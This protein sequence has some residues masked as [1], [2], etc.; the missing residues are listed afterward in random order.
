MTVNECVR[1]YGDPD[2]FAEVEE[3]KILYEEVGPSSDEDALGAKY[4]KWQ[5]NLNGVQLHGISNPSGEVFRIRYL[6]DK[7]QSGWVESRKSL[8]RSYSGVWKRLEPSDAELMI[9]VILFP[10]L[11]LILDKPEVASTP[12]GKLYA[13]QGSSYLHVYNARND[14]YR[15]KLSEAEHKQN[16]PQDYAK[17]QKIRKLG[18]ELKAEK[19][20]KKREEL[21]GVLDELD[22]ERRAEKRMK[23]R[24]RRNQRSNSAREKNVYAVS[25]PR[26]LATPTVSK[27]FKYIYGKPTNVYHSSSYNQTRTT[28]PQKVPHKPLSPEERERYLEEGAKTRATMASQLKKRNQRMKAAN[29]TA[30]K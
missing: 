18:V 6:F 25:T 13:Y 14:E 4:V 1:L 17:L 20:S 9:G 11:P 2:N 21:A 16:N 19:D 22:W 10:L 8:K 3:L 29:N 30:I 15:A 26:T 7:Q 23:E 5:W 27:D 28:I 12:S 24:V